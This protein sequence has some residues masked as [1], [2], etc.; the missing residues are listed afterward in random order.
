MIHRTVL[1]SI[2][3]FIGVLLENY[4]G[5]LPA[6][7]S[8][9]QVALLPVADRHVKHC[10]TLAAELTEAGVRTSLDDSK[11]SVGKKIRNAEM[12]KSPYMLVVGDKEAES[13]KL[14]V[15]S[16]VDGDLGLMST[17]ELVKLINNK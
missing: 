3:R 8:P 12:S 17:A 10:E 7:L 9:V 1:G 13:G 2:E 16:Y 5:A 4:A 11:E 15:R 14:S 6:W